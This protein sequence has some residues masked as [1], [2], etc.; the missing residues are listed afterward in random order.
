MKAAKQNKT[1]LRATK[2]KCNPI[3]TFPVPRSMVLKK[4]IS[5]QSPEKFCKCPLTGKKQTKKQ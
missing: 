4:K 5:Q 2:L 3:I 1:N